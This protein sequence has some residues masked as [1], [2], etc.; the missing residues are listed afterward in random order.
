MRMKERTKEL[1][2]NFFASKNIFVFRYGI[3][4]RHN[5]V[6]SVRRVK[7][8]RRLLLKYHEA[9]QLIS[10]VEATKRVP[11]ALAE[12]GVAYGG[13]AKL[14]SEYADGRILHLF[15]TFEGLPQPGRDD[16]PRFSLGD[17][18]CSLEGVRAYVSGS[19]VVFHQGVFPETG[20][21][22]SD[23]CFAFVHLDVDLYESTLE[24][25][26][27]FYPRMSRGGI[28]MSHDY[29]ISNGVNKAFREFFVDKP[30]P[31]IELTGHQCMLVKL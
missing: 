31:V 7:S 26:R 8:E 1:I 16:S 19:S 15:D 2:A 24:C 20:A 23:E 12:V 30:E 9:C 28:I 22:V 25:L 3:G 18:R 10:N 11:G 5:W 14:I 13:S 27:F 29:L 4:H 6:R 17:F 21:V